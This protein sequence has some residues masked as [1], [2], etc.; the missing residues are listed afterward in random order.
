MTINGEHRRRTEA[1][2]TDGFRA[3]NPPR[4]GVVP[5]VVLVIGRV[6]AGQGAEQVRVGPVREQH[7]Q[8]P[9][10]GGLEGMRVQAQADFCRS[11]RSVGSS[12]V[13][14]APAASMAVRTSAAASWKTVGN[15]SISRPGSLAA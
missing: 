7:V 11:V 8:S 3:D 10:R 15:W 14:G 12:R 13:S 9:L 1:L 6:G 2:T 5:G 4:D